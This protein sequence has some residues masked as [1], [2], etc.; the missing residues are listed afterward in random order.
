MR[1][2]TATQLGLNTKGSFKGSLPLTLVKYHLTQQSEHEHP[3]NERPNN[4]VWD[5]THLHIQ[6]KA[7]VDL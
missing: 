4:T 7:D 6:S 1:T 2:L 5:F 3:T